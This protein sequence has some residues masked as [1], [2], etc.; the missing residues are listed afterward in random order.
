MSKHALLHVIVRSQG[1]SSFIET[2]SQTAVCALLSVTAVT[3]PI[4]TV[5]SVRYH[6]K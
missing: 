6:S 4:M 5:I 3:E 2:A 1:V